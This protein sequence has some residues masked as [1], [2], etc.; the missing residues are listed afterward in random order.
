MKKI[1]FLIFFLYGFVNLSEST[2]AATNLVNLPS[3]TH[4]YSRTPYGDPGLNTALYSGTKSYDENWSTCAG[5][6][7]GGG[8]GY[9]SGTRSE[10]IISEHIFAIPY[11]VEQIKYQI[12][13]EASSGGPDGGR[14]MT[15]E[16]YVQYQQNNG[17]WTTLIGSSFSA[18]G[19]GNDALSKDTELVTYNTP[20]DNVTG[21][22]AYAYSRSSTTEGGIGG[23][24]FIYEIQALGVTDIG[25]RAFDGTNV[26]KIAC[27]PA[28][29]LTSSL[30]ISKNSTTY[31]IVLV[32]P[33]DPRASK[34][35]IKTGSGIKALEKLN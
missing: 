33:V 6:T 26:I 11:R 27:E 7:W 18:N 29:I 13:A 10:T 5:V 20:I 1:L 24:V 3:T 4:N 25:L 9:Y 28:G 15:Y 8:G 16:I 14:G 35:R 31:A 23:K 22:R 2:W 21:I 19:G 17:P 12:Y 32:D 34:I 30:R